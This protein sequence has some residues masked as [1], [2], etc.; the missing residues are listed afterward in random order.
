MNLSDGS[1]RLRFFGNRVLRGISEP[2]TQEVTGEWRRL[3]GSELQIH[4][5]KY[6]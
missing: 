5:K 6:Y 4:F 2:K 1:R 3:R